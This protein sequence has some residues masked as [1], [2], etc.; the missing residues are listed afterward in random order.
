MTGFLTNRF[1]VAPVQDGQDPKKSADGDE[2]T[3]ILR[4]CQSGGAEYYQLESVSN[5]MKYLRIFKLGD[6]V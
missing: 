3:F 5:M 2:A 6:G 4:K 1:I